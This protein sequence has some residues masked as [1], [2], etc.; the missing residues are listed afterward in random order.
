MFGGMYVNFSVNGTAIPGVDYLPLVSPA[1]IGQKGYGVILVQTLPDP[2]S[3]ICPPGVQRH[4]NLGTWP[5]IC[6]RRI[7]VS[8]NDD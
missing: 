4:G 6:T 1:Y 2:Q 3:I 5:K 8:S 7:Q